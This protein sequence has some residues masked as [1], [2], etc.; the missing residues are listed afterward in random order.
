MFGNAMQGRAYKYVNL[1]HA[2]PL[3]KATKN[4]FVVVR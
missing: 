3:F 4:L 1:K 2:K